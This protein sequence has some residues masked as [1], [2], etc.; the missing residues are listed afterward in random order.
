MLKLER[1]HHH[2][3]NSDGGWFKFVLYILLGPNIHISYKREQRVFYLN[4]KKM[5]VESF[6]SF[7][8]REKER[9]GEWKGKRVREKEQNSEHQR[10][11]G[12]EGRKREK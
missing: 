11:R 4:R 7:I 5:S 2:R 10:G 3:S 6:K 12:R 9:E 1:E 8:L